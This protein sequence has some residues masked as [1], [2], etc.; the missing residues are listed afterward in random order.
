[1]PTHAYLFGE[2]QAR[3]LLAVDPETAPDLLYSAS[4]QGIPAAV[5]GVT[6]ND[7]LTLPQGETISVAE[8]RETHEGWLPAYMASQPA[9]VPA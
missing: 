8:L 6:G 1:V 3:Y 2:D 5:I 4:A 9:G 7:H